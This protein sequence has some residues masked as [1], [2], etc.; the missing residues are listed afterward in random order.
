MGCNGKLNNDFNLYII[1][2]NVKKTLSNEWF[3]FY[4]FEYF[5]SSFSRLKVKCIESFLI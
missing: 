3:F 2:Q 5:L 1:P 4:V